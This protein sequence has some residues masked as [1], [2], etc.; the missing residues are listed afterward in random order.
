MLNP[1]NSA[2]QRIQVGL[3]GLVVVLLFVSIANMALERAKPNTAIATG[4]GGPTG[5]EIASEGKAVIADPAIAAGIGP[6]VNKNAIK[7]SA[8]ALTKQDTSP[9]PAR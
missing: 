7:P 6:V 1:R 3:V 9:A 8:P 4:Q 2:L 5:T